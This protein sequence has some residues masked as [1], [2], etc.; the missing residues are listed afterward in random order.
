MKEE[1]IDNDPDW[2]DG[3]LEPDYYFCSCCNHTQSK[4]AMG[5]GCKNCGMFNVM[6]EGYF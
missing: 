3:F 6:E 4:P 1:Y 2:N 5:N